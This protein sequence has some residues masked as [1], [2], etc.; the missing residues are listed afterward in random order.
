MRVSLQRVGITQN[1]LHLQ[2]AHSSLG[3][4]WLMSSLFTPF[5]AT[6]ERPLVNFQVS[7]LPDVRTSVYF[8][9]SDHMSSW[10]LFPSFWRKNYNSKIQDENRMFQLQESHHLT[11][12]L[13]KEQQVPSFSKFSVVVSNSFNHCGFRDMHLSTFGGIF[14]IYIPLIF[15]CFFLRVNDGTSYF[16]KE[17]RICFALVFYLWATE[18]RH[19]WP[20]CLVVSGS[21]VVKPHHV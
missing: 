13:D 3:D 1:H 8:S 11:A 9:D 15:L 19:W 10:G 5:Y 21:T 12:M 2:K 17:G 20:R 6:E 4:G 16:S 7:V 18:R 14:C